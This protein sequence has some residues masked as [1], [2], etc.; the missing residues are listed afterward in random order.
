MT[1]ELIEW[2]DAFGA[3][4]GWEFEDE[5]DPAVTRVSSVGY[6]IRETDE[7]V[8]L[9]PHVSSPGEGRR[10]QLAGHIAIPKRQIVARFECVTSSSALLSACPAPE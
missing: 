5:L 10:R 6:V 3:P 2:V 4:A 9:A 7:F 1:P 8:M